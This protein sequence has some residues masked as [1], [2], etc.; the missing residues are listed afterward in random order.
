MAAPKKIAGLDN[1]N[2]YLAKDIKDRTFFVGF[3]L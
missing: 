2:S 1:Q 3:D